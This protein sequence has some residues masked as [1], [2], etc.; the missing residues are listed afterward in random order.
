MTLGTPQDAQK[1]PQQSKASVLATGFV[2]AWRGKSH[3]TESGGVS[4]KAGYD[5]LLRKAFIWL[6][7]L[8]TAQ[9]DKV[10]GTGTAAF[11]T[12]AA[13]YYIAN[14]GLSIL[15]NV[16]LMGVPMPPFIKRALEVL[17][18]QSSKSDP[19]AFDNKTK[20]PE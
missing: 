11:Q 12:A 17:L 16:A 6:V 2:C 5:G 1:E 7:I 9:L 18:E 20:E 10:L 8:L 3:K 13:F 19:K 4:S 15:E 14:E